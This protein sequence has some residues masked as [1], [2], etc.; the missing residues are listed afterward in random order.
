M[1]ACG[2]SNEVNHGGGRDLV[3]PREMMVVQ[4]HTLG[5]QSDE[6]LVAMPARKKS[7]GKT[8]ITVPSFHTIILCFMGIYIPLEVYTLCS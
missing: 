1:S 3:V 8:F 4:F 5:P 7:Y 6:E 2:R